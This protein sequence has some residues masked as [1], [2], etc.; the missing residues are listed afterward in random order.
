MKRYILPLTILLATLSCSQTPSQLNTKQNTEINSKN[1]I[2]KTLRQ[3]KHYAQEPKYVIYHTNGMCNFEIFINDIKVSKSFN[4][5]SFSTGNEIN[6]YL[7]GKTNTLKIILY[8]REDQAKLDA[9]TEF[10]LKVESYENTDKLSTEKQQDNL[11]AYS[12]PKDNDRLFNGA[13]KESFEEE[14]IFTLSNVP[15]AIDGWKES[16]DLRSFDKKIL[17]GTALQAY[18][19]IQDAFKAKDTDKIARLSYSRIK[20][21]AISQYFDKDEIEERWNEVASIA[22]ADHLEFAPLDHY[23]LVFYGEGRLAGLKSIRKNKGSRG[24]SALSY[25]FKQNDSWTEAELDYL[26]HIPKNKTEFEIY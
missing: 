4:N 14:K 12:A 20:D 24:T 15:F 8:P 23:E 11:F 1:I 13:G 26:I 25:K 7:N 16:Q 21:Q 9:Q 2:E 18:K 6:P 17:E 5:K 3:I 19:M 10:D 22:K